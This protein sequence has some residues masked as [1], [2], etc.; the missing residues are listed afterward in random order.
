MDIV[1]VGS[2]NADLFSYVERFPK[3]GETLCGK[4]FVIGCGGKGANQCVMSAKLGAK[5]AMIGCVG[6]DV[7]GE[8]FLKAFSTAGVDITNLKTVLSATTGVATI[9]VNEK[10]ENSIVIT[11]GA[12]NCISTDQV[13]AS[14]DTIVKAKVALFQLEVDLATTLYALKIAYENG[15]TTIFNPAPA[16]KELPNEFLMYSSILCCN[17]TEAEILTGLS[18]NLDFPVTDCENAVRNLLS[19]GPLKV[20]LTMGSYGA[21]F[22]EK[23]SDAVHHILTPPS[24]VD[25]VVDTTGAGDCFVGSLAYFLAQ[26]KDLSFNEV[27][28]RS[29]AIAS[30]SVTK[31]GTQTSYPSLNDLPEDLIQ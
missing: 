2:C 3:V 17:E 29:V 19:K 20:V 6:D 26:R 25:K 11:K 1:V 30:I 22:G 12:N 16:L 15:V 14:I 13:E 18:I 4:K 24:I 5:T 21:I 8:M 23:G 9:T 7:F 28:R 27:V 31:H 10:G